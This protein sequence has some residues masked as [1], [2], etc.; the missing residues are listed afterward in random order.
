MDTITILPN[1]NDGKAISFSAMT[2]DHEAV[3]RTAGEALDALTSKTHSEICEPIIIQQFQADRYFSEAQ[4][5]RLTELMSHWHQARDANAELSPD[6]R[7]ELERLL[8]EEMLGATKRSEF[9]LN[10]AESFRDLYI[11]RRAQGSKFD[12]L[13]FFLGLFLMMLLPQITYMAFG[14]PMKI[15]VLA[16][17][18]GGVGAAIALLSYSR[19][20][21]TMRR[22]LGLILDQQRALAQRL[23]RSEQLS[24]SHQE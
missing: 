19:Q 12:D 23:L 3:G 22:D 7:G 18:M 2:S 5:Q 13:M 17:I 4:R 16:P 20:M 8:D 10:Q 14:S 11:K 6:L 21:K 1:E 9:A 24:N 15:A